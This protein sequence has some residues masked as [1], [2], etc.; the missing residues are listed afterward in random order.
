MVALRRAGDDAGRRAG[1]VEGLFTWLPIY[2]ERGW[3]L[4]VMRYRPDA[5]HG[6][7]EFL[8]AQSAIG[9]RDEGAA[10]ISLDIAPMARIE[11]PGAEV[12]AAQ[13]GLDLLTSLLEPF[14]HFA[15]LY[16]FKRKFAPVWSPV[17]LAYPGLVD[18]PKVIVAIFHAVLPQMGLKDVAADLGRELVKTPEHLLDTIHHRLADVRDRVAVAADKT[19]PGVPTGAKQTR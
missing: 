2:A 1:R 9:F 16:A 13:K 18:L 11:R 10:M 8:I 19:P 4:D 15:P 14:S 5:M 12:T 17:Y 3:V 7:M 6:V